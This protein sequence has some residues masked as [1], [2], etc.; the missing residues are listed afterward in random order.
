LSWFD[1]AHLTAVVWAAAAAAADAEVGADDAADRN[2]TD[3]VL[4]MRGASAN[5]RH[6]VCSGFV[7]GGRVNC[8]PLNYG[9]SEKFSLV[10]KFSSKNAKLGAE[11]P[12]FG[13][14]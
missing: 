4:R 9:L 13:E 12:H 3:P 1:E 8:P 7:A 10:E 6:F 5:V 2:A 11:N 14:I